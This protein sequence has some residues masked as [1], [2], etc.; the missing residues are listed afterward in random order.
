MDKVY[1]IYVKNECIYHSLTKEK[2]KELWDFVQKITWITEIHED[3]IQYEEVSIDKE[4]SLN[5]S[6]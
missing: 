1:H 4:F 5:S 2:F 3:D 6:Y